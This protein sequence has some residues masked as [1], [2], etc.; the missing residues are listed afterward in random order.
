[1][2]ITSVRIQSD[3][4]ERLDEVA[5][6][7]HRS[8]SSIINQAV[9]EFLTHQQQEQQRWQETLV[10]LESVRQGQ[11]VSGDAA[12][13]WVESWGTDAELSPPKTSP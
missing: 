7:L 5:A 1:M 11:V 6:K 9:S 2:A 8:K 10:A 4:S 3:L 13:T 12:Q